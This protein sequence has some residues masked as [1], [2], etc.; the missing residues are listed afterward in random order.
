MTKRRVAFK[1]VFATLL[2]LVFAISLLS[3]GVSHS[4]NAATPQKGCGR[5]T[6]AEIIA[7]IK[8][9]IKNDSLHRFDSQLKHINVDSRKKI[10]TL[11]GFVNGRSQVR[12]VGNFATTTR[13]VKKVVNR[14]RDRFIVGCGAGT[15]PCG[16]ICIPRTASCNIE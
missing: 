3:A 7:A 13:C 12:A 16:D 11:D 9:K 5:V 2:V 6:D 8:D 14:L 10:V 15:K 1:V 4:A